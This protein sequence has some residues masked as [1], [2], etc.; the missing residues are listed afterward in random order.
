MSDPILDALA[1]DP[2]S[3]SNDTSA[4]YNTAGT[5]SADT[6]GG[7]DFSKVNW[8]NLLSKYGPA[9]VGSLLGAT[10]VLN[11]APQKSGYQGGI[12]KYT[13]VRQQIPIDTTPRRPGG[14]GRRYF[15]DMAYVPKTGIATPAAP[16]APVEPAVV[17][18]AQGG[19]IGYAQGGL[20]DLG[21]YLGGTTDGM[22]DK[23]PTTIDKKQP[24]SLS[25]GE[26]IVPAD[27]VSALGSGNSSAGAK[28]LYSMMDRIRKNA[29]GTTKQIKQANLKK[30]LPA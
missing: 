19:M 7:F 4:I 14:A 1:E 2:N 24:A 25:H 13:A 9:A 11:S 27:V 28:V 12:P 26:F 8:G 29:H 22:A 21:Y 10:G 23:I 16:V 20:A 5:G 6:G 30:T 3:P 15:T 18:V 17:P